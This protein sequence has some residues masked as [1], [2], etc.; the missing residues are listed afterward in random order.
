VD[1]DSWMEK[2]VPSGD[3]RLKADNALQ[4]HK[5]PSWLAACQIA[6]QNAKRMYSAAA[7][8][9]SEYFHRLSADA[10]TDSQGLIP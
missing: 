4:Q 1:A 5:K 2:E 9:I 8:R 3:G 6:R 10:G 7:R